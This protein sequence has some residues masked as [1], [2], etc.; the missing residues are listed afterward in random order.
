MDLHPA[1]ADAA[2]HDA[3]I[4]GGVPPDAAPAD[5]GSWRTRIAA[6]LT[7]QVGKSPITA[8]ERDWFVATALAVRDSVLDR[9]FESTKRTYD[10]GAKR[11][12]YLSLEFLIGRLLFDT[13]GNLGLMDTV[14][15]A[16]A[17]EG[18][19]IDRL[20]GEEPDAALGNGGLGRLAACFM[21][22]MATLGI[23]SFGYGIRYEH[24]LFRQVLEHG[25][26]QELPEDWLQLGNPWE[27]ERPEVAYPIGFGGTVSAQAAPDGRIAQLAH[28]RPH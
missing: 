4:S 19:D 27:F 20:R 13:I 15:E 2:S 5:A 12:Y 11:V 23:P 7:Y 6:K 24:G 9:W 10:A 18:V 3:A 25:V 1:S 17:A 14:R 8:S 26:Q 21:E 22:S 16:L 28:N